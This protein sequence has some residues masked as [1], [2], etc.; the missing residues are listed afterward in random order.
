MKRF[1]ALCAFFCFTTT[2]LMA[3]LEINGMPLRRTFSNLG[4][5]AGISTTGIGIHLATPLTRS[6]T[7]RAGYNFSPISY[8]YTY[9]DFDPV[10]V[11]GA[12]I[13]VPDLDAKGDLNF[14]AGQ[15]LIDW[16]PFRKG[17][18]SF[19]I[20]AGMVFGSSRIIQ[21][22]GQFDP[23]DP[24]FKAI[25]DA[26]LIHEIEVEI[27]DQIVHPN[28]D[29]SMDAAIQVQGARPYVGL[30]FGRAIPRRRVGFRFEM[31][32]QFLGT[33]KVVSS[34]LE[35]G[36]DSDGD[37][38]DFNKILKD[39]TLYPNISFQLTYRLFTDKIR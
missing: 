14:N 12:S 39:I 2:S 30:G 4:I 1:L 26:G 7:L 3:Q 6:L 20:T 5:S 8:D 29:G 21:V 37:I 22:H 33:P 38:S 13:E 17:T 9:D 25:K 36:Y 18:S 35:D 24:N 34:N 28:A 10:Q 11:S 27:G 31:G 23:N 16:V 19:F 32:V 15:L